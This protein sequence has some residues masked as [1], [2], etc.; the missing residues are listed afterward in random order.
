LIAD[1]F[2]KTTR[3]TPKRVIEACRSRLSEYDER[4]RKLKRGV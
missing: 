3:Q 4:A 1:V 2:A